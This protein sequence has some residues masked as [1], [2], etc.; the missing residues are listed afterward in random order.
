MSQP[1][2]NIERKY[3]KDVGLH[4]LFYE[5]S[6]AIGY[7]IEII[8]K[9]YLEDLEKLIDLWTAQKYIEVYKDSRDREYG[10]A[11]PSDSV[12]NS[13]PWYI[14]MYHARLLDTGENDPLIVIVFEEID[15]DGQIST[16]ASLRFMA[17]HDD[18]FGPVGR[19]KYNEAQMRVIRMEIDGYIQEGNRFSEEQRRLNKEMRESSQ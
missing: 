8:E 6:E 5:I 2:R 10:R 18:L 16:I 15:E 17:D 14:G 19:T 1:N 3:I 9:D 7:D 12:N 11:K 13:V 4:S